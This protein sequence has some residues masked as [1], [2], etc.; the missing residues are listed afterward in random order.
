[1]AEESSALD[2]V[3]GSKVLPLADRSITRREAH[4]MTDRDGTLEV[5]VAPA[6]WPGD[7]A[8][9]GLDMTWAWLW[10]TKISGVTV[11]WSCEIHVRTAALLR[12]DARWRRIAHPPL[13]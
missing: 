2:Q 5:N 11:V 4:D 7:G 1:M 12:D 6:E 3:L 8:A 13:L 10:K 9:P